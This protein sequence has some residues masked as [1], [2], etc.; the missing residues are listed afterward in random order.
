MGIMDI[1]S[2]VRPELMT[3]LIGIRPGEKLHEQMIGSEDAPFTYDYQDHFRIFPQILPH[4]VMGNL[5]ANRVPEGFTYSSDANTSWMTTEELSEW[6]SRN[7][8]R[9]GEF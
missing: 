8:T 3:K 5:E 7:V 4:L 1:A 2:V 6:L 9:I